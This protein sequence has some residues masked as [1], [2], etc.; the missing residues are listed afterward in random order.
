MRSSDSSLM[1]AFFG[2]LGGV[3]G[4]RGLLFARSSGRS[5]EEEAQMGRATSQI[6]DRRTGSSF[7]LR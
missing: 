6:C 5:L 7:C 1:I 4:R 3:V 2:V